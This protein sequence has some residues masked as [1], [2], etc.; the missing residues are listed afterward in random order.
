M[1]NRRSTVTSRCSLVKVIGPVACN[2]YNEGRCVAVIL[3]HFTAYQLQVN[4][5]ELAKH[6][7]LFLQCAQLPI[8]Q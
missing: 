2:Y 6:G 7:F 8:P 1:G 4:R 5:Y 3:M